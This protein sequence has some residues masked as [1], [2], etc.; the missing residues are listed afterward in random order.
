MFKIPLVKN[1]YLHLVLK[2]KYPKITRPEDG[3]FPWTRLTKYLGI[4][5][6]YLKYYRVRNK[7]VV[8]QVMLPLPQFVLE[9][10]YIRYYGKKLS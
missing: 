6:S 4:R 1:L 7:E 2:W 5:L 8:L 9:L 3:R 10:Q